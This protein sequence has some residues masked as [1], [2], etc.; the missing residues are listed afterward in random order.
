MLHLI[1]L[2]IG[3][4]CTVIFLFVRIKYAG[5]KGLLTKIMASTCF[6]ALAIYAESQSPIHHYGLLIIAGL[7]LGLIGDIFLDLRQIYAQDRQ[8]YTASGMIAFSAGHLPFICAITQDAQIPLRYFAIALGAALLFALCVAL[9]E[10]PL[11]LCYKQLKALSVFYSFILALMAACAIAAA[12]LHGLTS[13]RYNTFAVAG[14]LFI[15]SDLILSG[16]YFDCDQRKN[17]PPHVLANHI[18]YYAAQF[19]IAFSIAL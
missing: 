16:I 2:G 1:I 18:T 17:T 11:H 6:V 15:V 8:L 14:I 10:K 7:G 9:L 4:I 19:L 5:T 13:T 3:L 12:L